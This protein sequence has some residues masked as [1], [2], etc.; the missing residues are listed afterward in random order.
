[1][2]VQGSH[3]SCDMTWINNDNNYIVMASLFWYIFLPPMSLF[4]TRFG[5]LPSLPSD[6]LLEWPH[7]RSLP[8]LILLRLKKILQFAK[9][10]IAKCSGPLQH[11]R[12]ALEIIILHKGHSSTDTNFSKPFLTLPNL[13]SWS[14]LVHC[15]N[16]ENSYKEMY[17]EYHQ[18]YRA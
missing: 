9:S 15:E 16:H 13:S 12:S 7:N 8:T 6:I 18:S 4:V 14:A 11:C 17:D 10:L 3:S 1:M 2:I 5:Y